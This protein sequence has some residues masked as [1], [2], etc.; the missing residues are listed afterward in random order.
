[1]DG[2]SHTA[3]QRLTRGVA[4]IDKGLAVI[5]QIAFALAAFGILLIVGLTVADITGRF[6][7]ASPVRGTV[8]LTRV[9]MVAVVFLGLGYAEYKHSHIK[10]DILLLVLPKR[11]QTVISKTAQVVVCLVVLFMAWALL[12]FTGRLDASGQVTS[13]LR[14]PLLYFGWLATG[15][16]VL[17]VAVAIRNLFRP[18]PVGDD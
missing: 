6:F 10:V 8:E 18:D 5:V 12:E 16:A 17:F 11:V 1:M 15:G 14:L 7:F 13:T 4:A 9:T 3:K 2:V